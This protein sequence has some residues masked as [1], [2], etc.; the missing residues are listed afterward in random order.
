MII[1][2]VLALE[3]LR[4]PIEILS[5]ALVFL[6]PF[7]EPKENC[8]WRAAL[9]FC[10]FAALSLL[11]F[12]IF[13]DKDHPRL[14][15][16]QGVW[17]F[18][19]AI[20]PLFFA[21]ACFRI[22]WCDA[23]FLNISAFAMQNIV[24]VF[25]NQFLARN[26]FPALREHLS[27]YV[28]VSAAVCLLVYGLAYRLFAQHLSRCGN[29]LF[30]DAPKDLLLYCALF[31][32]TIVCLFYFQSLFEN[33][34]GIS[35]RTS[36][37]PGMMYSIFLLTIQYSM[38][39][40]KSY[41]SENAVLEQMLRSSE[42]Y[43]EMSKE[44]IAIINRKCHDM[45]H[46]LKI[47]SMVSD[48][49]RQ[50]YIDEA[51]ENLAFYQQLVHSENPVINTILAEKG[52]FCEERG[53]ALSCAVDDVDMGFIKVTDLYAMLGNALDN[54]IEYV[55]GLE[56][57]ELQVISFRISESRGFLNIQVV[58]PYRGPGLSPGELPESSHT[59]ETGYHG[60]GLKSIR[61]LAQKYGGGME[62]ST[63]DG[64]FTLQI[65]MPLA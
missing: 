7:A 29:H 11:Y 35:A 50:Q 30:D 32:L 16:F 37:L 31:A 9:A 58:N 25:V 19:F 38:F 46:Q 62:I 5:A 48:E 65:T 52:L 1:T 10:G 21:K 17:Y 47:L 15:A 61:Y 26:Q 57:A 23:L 39:R 34:E 20:C 36:W 6:V 40:M 33:T 56:E 64:L 13:L 2:P 8:R 49:E 43:Y 28:L 55:G 27:L 63:A 18:L 51:R 54:A 53:I 3:E 4:F 44:N 14:W 22:G 45:K 41:S 12:P 42:R 59:E 24:Y 60:Y